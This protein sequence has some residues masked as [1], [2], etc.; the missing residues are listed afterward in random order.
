MDVDKR[1]SA[2]QALNHPW[3]KDNKSK[4]MYNEIKDKNTIKK[5]IEN[6]KK[7]KRDSVIQETALA[8]IVHNFS[9]MPD[10]INA[11]K[12]F[13]QID[14]N[15]DGKITKDEFLKGLEKKINHKNL[16]SEVDKIF[17]NI[18]MDKNGY[19]EYEEFVRAAVNKE[20][21]MDEEILRFAFRYF[22]K[23]NSKSITF[24]EIEDLFADS[25]SDK[26]NV[27][28][29]LNKI[30]KEVDVNGDG[31]ITFNEFAAVMKR[32]VK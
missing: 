1:I 21:I 9:Q 24:S 11:C 5:M 29:Y 14:V 27:H 25:I 16:K 2:E 8:Y 4:E 17:N 26:N 28:D 7:Y 31:K 6:L 12:L 19:I 15:G 3:F 10:V 32:M 30:I 23:D 18:D 13:N 22:D 20:F